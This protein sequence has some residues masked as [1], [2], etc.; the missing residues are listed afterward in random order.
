MFQ[1]VNRK[2]TA[3]YLHRVAGRG[4]TLR[5]TLQRSPEGA[6]AELPGGHEV[7]ENVNGQASVRRTRPRLIM[8]EE[9]AAVRSALARHGLDAW[10]VHVKDRHITIFEP[11]LDAAQVASRFT[12]RA[13]MPPGIGAKV[14]AMVRE[15][16]GDAAMDAWLQERR[17]G[18]QR[19]LEETMRYS[20][21]LRF[22]L[23]DPK[24]RS[25]RVAR[26]TWSGDGGWYVL[27]VAP[28]AKALVRYLKH[29]GKDSFFD[30]A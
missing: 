29:L 16:I 20:P 5:Y 19:R 27:D 21:V 6:L 30:L 23:A 17:E 8:A 3:Y 4:G 14:E 11:D 28:L 22:E 18:V 10:R 13:T 9:E 1:Y 25:F 2:G 15:R 7:V 12:S 24:R 26:M